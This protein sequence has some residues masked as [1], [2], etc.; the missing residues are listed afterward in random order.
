MNYTDNAIEEYFNSMIEELEKVGDEL[1]VKY[2]LLPLSVYV[3]NK[4]T[5]DVWY[6]RTRSRW[7]I[8]LEE[9]LVKDG[10]AGKFYNMGEFGVGVL[11]N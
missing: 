6:L 9:L 4:I 3:I 5:S 1:I 7:S 10:I 2:N 11:I 8:E